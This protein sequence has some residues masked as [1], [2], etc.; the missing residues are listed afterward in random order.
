MWI[1]GSACSL[2]NAWE[3]SNTLQVCSSIINSRSLP[4]GEE[5]F[6]CP[7]PSPSPGHLS[8]PVL[9]YWSQGCSVQ[10][11]HLLDAPS[12]RHKTCH[13][14][15][16]D[17]IAAVAALLLA[18]Y[19]CLFRPWFPSGSYWSAVLLLSSRLPLFCGLWIQGSYWA[20]HS[21][22]GPHQE[23][24]TQPQA[25]A[26]C[27][28]LPDDTE[29]WPSPHGHSS[30]RSNAPPLEAPGHARLLIWDAKGPRG[31][32]FSTLEEALDLTLSFERKE[33]LLDGNIIYPRR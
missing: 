18:V 1:I 6:W 14:N 22:T 12:S 7:S 33:E 21:S 9:A 26:S 15:V 19:S 3:I 11:L 24:A 30:V 20:S 5:L 8:S 25:A 4:S 17:V 13:L 27:C 32:H 31:R 2:N 28:H 23:P 10:A 16:R 29:H